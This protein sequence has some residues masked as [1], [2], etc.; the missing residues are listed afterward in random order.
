MPLLQAP[1][2]SWLSS[3]GGKSHLLL[4]DTQS[5]RPPKLIGF[6]YYKSLK[7]GTGL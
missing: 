3:D 5:T 2:K 4:M 7:L 1:D 6:K